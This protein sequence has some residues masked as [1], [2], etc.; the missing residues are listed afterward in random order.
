MVDLVL[1]PLTLGDLHEYV[2]LHGAA[3][4][5]SKLWS[6]RAPNRCRARAGDRT[7]LAHIATVGVIERGGNG[8]T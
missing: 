8:K 4:L 1:V 3:I 5:S 7:S 2:E 6:R